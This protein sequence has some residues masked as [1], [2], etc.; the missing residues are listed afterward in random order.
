MP[1]RSAGSFL[2]DD[3]RRRRRRRSNGER[4]MKCER[5]RI[6]GGSA[7]FNRPHESPVRVLSSHLYSLFLSL[8]FVR[9]VSRCVEAR[10]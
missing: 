3:D 10:E 4:L 2:D 1:L 5:R 9:S 8:S 7:T 6:Y